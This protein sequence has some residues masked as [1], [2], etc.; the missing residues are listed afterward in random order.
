[1]GEILSNIS[2]LFAQGVMQIITAAIISGIGVIGGIIW[3]RRANLLKEVVEC[4]Q[5]IMKAVDKDS[6]GGKAITS[7]EMTKIITE[8]KDLYPAG[9]AV[10][11]D[12]KKKE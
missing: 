3:K 6:D 8:L 11:V 4:V 12:M 10:I 7:A 1:M 9:M 5:V 2:G